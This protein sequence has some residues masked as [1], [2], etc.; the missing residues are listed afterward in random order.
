MSGTGK[1]TVLE[2][3]ARRGYAT[4]ETD[5]SGWCVPE[6]SEYS[7]YDREWVWDEVRIAALLDDHQETHL[8]V[9]GCRPNQGKFYSRFDHVVVF[10]TR[11]EVMLERITSRTTNPFSKD[12]REQAAIIE[13]T[14]TIEP[15]LIQSADLV[16]VTTTMLPEQIANRLEALL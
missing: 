10:Q 14:R 9:A 8:F 15:L 12:S 1:S 7:R 6:D 5:E 13:D 2:I 11:L 3:L 4:V 16:I